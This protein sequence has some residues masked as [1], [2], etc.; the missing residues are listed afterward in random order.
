M[1]KM[2]LL[3][4]PQGTW[5]SLKI[6]K[7]ASRYMDQLKNTWVSLKV[8]RSAMDNLWSASRFLDQPWNTKVSHGKPKNLEAD[9]KISFQP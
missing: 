3:G 7:L 6:L 1:A 9:P 5:V 4:R 8:F 2:R